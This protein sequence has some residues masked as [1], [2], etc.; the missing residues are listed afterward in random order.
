ME[1]IQAELVNLAIVVIVGLAGFIT[2]RTT[3]FLKSKG[4]IAKLDANKEL[5]SIVVN[6]VEQAYKHLDGDEKLNVAKIELVRL[7]NE[8]KIKISEKEIDTL[9]EAVVKEMK[10]SHREEIGK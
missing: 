2:Q 6:A 4:I 10:D 3:S 5:V 7:M 9:I 8:K 1:A